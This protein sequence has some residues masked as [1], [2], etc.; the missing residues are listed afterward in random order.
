MFE[1][2]SLEKV[3]GSEPAPEDYYAGLVVCHAFYLLC[4]L[5]LSSE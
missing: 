5:L 1:I 4:P 3:Q 2:D